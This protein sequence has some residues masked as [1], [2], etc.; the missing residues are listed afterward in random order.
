MNIKYFI[1]DTVIIKKNGITGHVI[2]TPYSNNGKYKVVYILHHEIYHIDV[3]EK[4]LKG[5]E[6]YGKSQ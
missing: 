6:S 3:L 2:M 5:G 1:G 4:E